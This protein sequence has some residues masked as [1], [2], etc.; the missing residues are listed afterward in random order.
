MKLPDAKTDRDVDYHK[1]RAEDA[2]AEIDLLLYE[3]YGLGAEAIRMVES[4]TMAND[5]GSK[6]SYRGKTSTED[7]QAN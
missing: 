2:E 4:L 5:V 7:F 3:F 1:R 6:P